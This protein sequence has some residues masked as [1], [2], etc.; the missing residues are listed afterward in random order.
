MSQQENRTI[1]PVCDGK[2]KFNDMRLNS[3]PSNGGKSVIAMV[4]L[5]SSYDRD[6]DREKL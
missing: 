1:C 3:E 5:H 6:F 4:F 2:G